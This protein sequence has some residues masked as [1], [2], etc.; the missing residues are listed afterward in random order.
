MSDEEILKKAKA[1]LLKDTN[2]IVE[3]MCIN[4]VFKKNKEVVV[5]E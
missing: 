2:D 5:N 4:E 3:I 1:L